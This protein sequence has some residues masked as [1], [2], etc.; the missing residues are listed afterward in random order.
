MDEINASDSDVLNLHWVSSL[1][2]VADI[3]R[4]SKPVVW[5]LHDMWAFC[6]GEHYAPDGGEARFREGYRADNRP[7]SERGPDLNRQT[8]ET[9][10][11][12][13]ARKRF[14]IVSPSRWLA[15][16]ARG[17]VLFSG[18][19]VHVIPY[20]LDIEATWRPIPREAARIALG[21]PPDKRLILM[22]ADGGVADP[23][24]GSDL[25]R[26]SVARLVAPTRDDI[27]LVIFGQEMPA[28][29]NTWPCRVHWMGDVRDD[30]I[31]A[32]LYSSADVM[33]VPSRQEAF[34][35]TALEAQAC[36]TPVAAFQI[37]GLPD[38]VVHRET[39]W[40]ARPFDTGD[41]AEGLCW[42]LGDTNRRQG[43]S[44]SARDRALKMWSPAVVAPQYV[45]V[46]EQAMRDSR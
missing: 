38:I 28:G 7:P 8:W 33:V 1:L 20:P 19:A 35:Q 26:E 3:G 46:Y 41:L 10:R 17:S 34:G 25:L 4:L 5:T 27:E 15:E 22:G 31:L 40:L 45:R 9:K 21:L 14:T 11:R 32:L 43:L 6:G 12:A 16:C 44:Q 23:R 36:G 24:K 13:W 42:M 18:A 37:G 30:R 29:P 39:G 2:S